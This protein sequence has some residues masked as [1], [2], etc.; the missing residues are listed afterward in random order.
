MNV[1]IRKY[2]GFMLLLI[3]VL[4]ISTLAVKR[5]N[6]IEEY[7]KNYSEEQGIY[8]QIKSENGDFQ[9]FDGS[10]WH[11]FNMKGVQLTAF[12]P[13]YNRNDTRMR[14]PDFDSWLEDI[15][16]LNA[17]T[18]YVPYLQSADFYREIYWFNKSS[19][20]PIYLIQ[21]IPLKE[22]LSLEV[23]DVFDRK[24][25]RNLKKD[26]RTTV[27]AINGRCFSTGNKLYHSGV[28]MNDVSGYVLGYVVGESTS[29]QLV[30]LT[31]IENSEISSYE[32]KNLFVKN[33]SAM[34]CFVAETLD[35]L[36]EYEKENFKKQSLVSYYTVFDTDP[37]AHSN[38]NNITRNAS[39]NIENIGIYDRDV[40]PV[41]AGYGVHPSDLVFVETY[42]YRNYINDINLFHERP[43]VIMD[44]GV[45]T[46]RGISKTND[47]MGFDRGGDNEQQ[48]GVKLTKLLD[49]ISESGSA[50][51][52]VNSWQDNWNRNTVFNL[53]REYQEENLNQWQNVQASDECF[54]LMT[55]EYGD[56][57]PICY[58]DGNKEDWENDQ[59]VISGD[60]QL[61]VKSDFS[62]LYIMLEAENYSVDEE[63]IYLAI[64]LP[65]DTGNSKMENLGIDFGIPA[66]FIV[67]ISGYEDSRIRVH[68]R[69][70]IFSYKYKYYRNTLEK[71]DYRPGKN[72]IVFNRMYMLNRTNMYIGADAYE[73]RPQY[74]ETGNL[75]YGNSDPS[76]D[77]Y[78][79]IADYYINDDVIEI[80]V[81]WAL[82]N[83]VD[84]ITGS[85]IS[86]CY[87]TGKY[88]D[89]K[90]TKNIDFSL[91]R[92]SS[93]Y[94]S[95]T[96]KGTYFLP[97]LNKVKYHTR[98]KKSYQILKNYWGERMI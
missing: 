79:S 22:E 51:V 6:V 54:G 95:V 21:G 9:L 52:F 57:I 34:D 16:E 50:G 65:G 1:R 78:N 72:S 41:F 5:N 86:D 92:H 20:N 28:Y 49:I 39:I 31:N 38:D 83:F 53:I 2:T 98:L 85:Y 23:H 58:L 59:T 46:S 3:L 56:G 4:I 30:N 25:L 74:Y 32:G 27:A 8:F 76:S 71:L 80:R 45:S 96:E 97:G 10:S 19:D 13:G 40:D 18:L 89:I 26:I 37:L 91:G 36:L 77:E 29:P 63:S 43:V 47:T 17:N 55:I 11:D 88:A 66:D 62:Y 15:S 93:N 87:R 90:K 44:I 84:P 48:Q 42:D 82:V 33:G 14:I 69:L 70:D 94:V 60:V 7:R 12:Y 75:V 24:L 67:E 35:Y 73:L 61:K 81:P 64:D 68:E